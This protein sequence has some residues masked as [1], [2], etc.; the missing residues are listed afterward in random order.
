[1]KKKTLASHIIRNVL[2]FCAGLFLVTFSIYY[3]FTHQTIKEAARE[4]AILLATNTV[5]RIEKVLS[6]AEKIPENIAAMLESAFL[7][8]DSIIPFLKS[9]IENNKDMLTEYL[10]KHEYSTQEL[11][12]AMFDHILPKLKEMNLKPIFTGRFPINQ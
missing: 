12:K 11:H 3:S 9:I 8:K 6:P 2:I 5:N 7:S 1:M 10:I 4:N